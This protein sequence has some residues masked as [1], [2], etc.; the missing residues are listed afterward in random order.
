M[1]HE[2]KPA[3]WN[4]LGHANRIFALKWVDEHVLL[5]GGWDSVVHFWDTRVKR[6]VRHFFGPNISGESLDFQDGRILAGCY[7]AT[8][9]IQIWDF[10]TSKKL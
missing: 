1:A 5:S 2:F 6:S 4:N 8:N 7:A 10:G 3:D 9:Q